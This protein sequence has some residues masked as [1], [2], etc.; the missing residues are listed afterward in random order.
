VPVSRFTSSTEPVAIGYLLHQIP[1]LSCRLSSGAW[2]EPAGQ[3]QKYPYRWFCSHLMNNKPVTPRI[4]NQA[5]LIPVGI[6]RIARFIGVCHFPVLSLLETKR[7]YPPRPICPSEEKYRDR[8]SGCM[9]GT[10]NTG[11]LISRADI[12]GNRPQVIVIEMRDPDIM[13]AHPAGPVT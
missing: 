7:S 3:T 13:L 10:F 12:F 5:Y 11:V 6:D 2:T 1:C 8:L 9:K 4:D